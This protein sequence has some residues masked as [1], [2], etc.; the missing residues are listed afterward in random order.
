[1]TCQCIFNQETKY[2]LPKV[3]RKAKKLNRPINIEKEIGEFNKNMSLK[4]A[5]ESGEDHK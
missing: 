1:M 3:T 5:S 4:N 2:K